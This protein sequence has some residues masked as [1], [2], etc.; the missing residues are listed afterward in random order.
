VKE[1]DSIYRL[2]SDLPK[3]TPKKEV[4]AEPPREKTACDEL[5][6]LHEAM[7]GVKEI[8]HKNHRI[9]RKTDKTHGFSH[10]PDT[11]T[12]MRDAIEDHRSFTVTNMPEYMEGQVEGLN[13]LTMEKLRNGEFSIQ[14]ILDLHGYS[15]A[16]AYVLFQEFIGDAVLLGLNCVKVIHGRGL[17]S[18]DVP[19]LKEKLKEWI[20]RA[21]HRK[22]VVAF[23]SARMCEGGPGA[24]CILLRR[25]PE[26]KKLHIAG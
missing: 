24:T 23:S 12:Q 6:L 14:R 10:D 8:E 25:R 21:I 2:L 7:R 20:V 1:D 17:K 4:P 11:E 18:R 9:T 3:Y 16:D 13:P 19:V 5:A 22:W 15:A 26:K